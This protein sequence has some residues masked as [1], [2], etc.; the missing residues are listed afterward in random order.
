MIIPINTERVFEKFQYAFMIKVLKR[1][2]ESRFPNTINFMHGK[3]ISNIFH[4]AKV[5]T[6]LYFP[7]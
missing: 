7:E 2:L 6:I 4:R 3:P 1:E 5:H